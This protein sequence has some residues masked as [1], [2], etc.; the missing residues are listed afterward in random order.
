MVIAEYYDGARQGCVMIPASTNRLGWSLF[1]KEL[2]F[3]FS[4]DK[5]RPRNGGG[6]GDF[7]PANGGR[8]RQARNN[9]GNQQKLRNFE[10][11]GDKLGNNVILGDSTK[12][13]GR[14]THAFTFKLT[15]ENLALRVFKSE[16][17]KIKC[18]KLKPNDTKY[19]PLKVETWIKPSD[20]D[21][22]FNE[23]V[24]RPLILSNTKQAD[25]GPGKSGVLVKASHPILL[26]DIIGRS[27]SE[28]RVVTADPKAKAKGLLAQSHAL[29]AGGLKPIHGRVGESSN[30]G[31]CMPMEV[32][33]A[34]GA[35]TD[36]ERV[37]SSSV[38]DPD[39]GKDVSSAVTNFDVEETHGEAL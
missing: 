23:K 21:G 35:E 28:T 32:S 3:F 2:G 18:F 16:D 17:G 10:I 26:P 36:M 39:S 14:P 37:R 19:G 4:G 27:S 1:H 7:L 30:A 5:S 13:N 9:Y 34:P 31:G 11:L 6:S 38:V 12:L 8:N 33:D 25:S 22:L 24:Q 20:K 15:T 29:E